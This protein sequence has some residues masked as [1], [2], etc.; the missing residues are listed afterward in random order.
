MLTD[1]YIS[2]KPSTIWS[3]P[4]RLYQYSS[5]TFLA[6]QGVRTVVNLLGFGI[7]YVASSLSLQPAFYIHE[8]N[9]R[10]RR[11]RFGVFSSLLPIYVIF[12]L[13]IL[14]CKV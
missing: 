2:W 8:V 11:Y 14:I 6:C 7:A 13:C 12:L 10:N 1:V 3:T 5:S 4:S 9:A